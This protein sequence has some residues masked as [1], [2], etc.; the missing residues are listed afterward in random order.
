MAFRFC[1]LLYGLI[2]VWK[3]SILLTFERSMPESKGVFKT[4]KTYLERNRLGELLV[5]RKNL[6]P[7]QLKDAL[8]R[9]QFDSRSLGQ[10]LVQEGY[11]TPG[12]IRVAL[13]TQYA[14]RSMAAALTL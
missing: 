10:I 8:A 2:E 12:Q 9:Q 7:Q 1:Q 4:I 11:V 3:W 13:A 5:V 6:S 14:L